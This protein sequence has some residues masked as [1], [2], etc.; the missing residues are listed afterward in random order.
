MPDQRSALLAH[1]AASLR[2]L[3]EQAARPRSAPHPAHPVQRH[4]LRRRLQRAGPPPP[5]RRL[6]TTLARTLGADLQEWGS[7]WDALDQTLRDLPGVRCRTAP[8]RRPVQHHQPAQSTTANR[9]YSAED[10]CRP[11]YFNDDDSGSWLKCRAGNVLHSRIC[12]PMR[13]AFAGVRGPAAG[14]LPAAESGEMR[15]RR[16]T[17]RGRC[18]ADDP[19]RR[20]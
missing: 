12:R 18:R 5:S 19:G 1:F 3:R 14:R 6:T 13:M 11:H 9:P 16:G 20:S 8:R 4:S 2:Q 17:P 7:R 15:F 10:V